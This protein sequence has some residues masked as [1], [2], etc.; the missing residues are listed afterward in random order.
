MSDKLKQK[1]KEEIIKIR[2]SL[3]QDVKDL[4]EASR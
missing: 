2:D 3:A 1:I 4:D